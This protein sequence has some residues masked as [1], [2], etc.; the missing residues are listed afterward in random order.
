MGEAHPVYRYPEAYLDAIIHVD[1]AELWALEDGRTDA[2][3]IADQPHTRRKVLE[4]LAQPENEHVLNAMGDGG[5]D[6]W[7]HSEPGE[8]KTSF[9]NV[10]GGIR[11]PE[12]NNETVLWM[13]TLDELECLPLAP[14]MTVAV[15]EAS[16]TR[17]TRSRAPRRCRRSRSS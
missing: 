13:L 4:W 5:T 12:I 3:I 10:I 6:L 15:P 14:W 9:A 16:S 11:M 8:G 2:D 1:D 17:F 7:A